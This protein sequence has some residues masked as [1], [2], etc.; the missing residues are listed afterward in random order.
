MRTRRFELDD[1]PGAGRGS[2]SAPVVNICG[3]LVHAS[4]GRGES[5]AARLRALMGVDVH[6]VTTDDRVIV[7]MEDCADSTALDRM[8]DLA[9]WDGVAASSLVFHHFEDAAA[10]D[11]EIVG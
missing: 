5:V 3:V 1:G 8:R 10:L 11:G 7:V 4:P 6:A 9:T 2:A